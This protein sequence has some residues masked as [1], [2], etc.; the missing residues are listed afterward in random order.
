MV[1]LLQIYIKRQTGTRNLSILLRQRPFTDQYQ[2]LE[3][4]LFH[5]L[6]V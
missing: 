5:E 6:P 3:F 1:L 2:T 4:N